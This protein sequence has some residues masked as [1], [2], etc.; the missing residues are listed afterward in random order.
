V[1]L[2]EAVDRYPAYGFSKLF[3]VL[4][5]WEHPWNHKRVYPVYCLLKLDKRRRSK[6]RPA[7]PAPA[8][9]GCTGSGKPVLIDGLHE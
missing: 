1:V 6:K 7:E 3:R 2:Q 9:S 8:T 4:R 5:R